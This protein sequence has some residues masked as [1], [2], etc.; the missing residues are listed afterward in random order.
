MRLVGCKFVGGW[1]AY[2]GSIDPC[3][4]WNNRGVVGKHPTIVLKDELGTYF[5]IN[6]STCKPY[7]RDVLREKGGPIE[8]T[9][10][11][12]QNI[13]KANIMITTAI[14]KADD[15]KMIDDD[16]EF[17]SNFK[18]ESTKQ[19]GIEKI[20]KILKVVALK[21]EAFFWYNGTP[22]DYEDPDDIKPYDSKSL[23]IE[24]RKAIIEAL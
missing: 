11:V 22:N 17:G 15:Y 6:L 24:L 1:R 10:K 16:F 21:S 7:L 23:A 3:G 9:F 5:L 20:K 19:E 4:K 8:F 2:P 12:G 13:K 18:C 14:I